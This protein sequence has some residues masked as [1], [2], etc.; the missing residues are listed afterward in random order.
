M[1]NYIANLYYTLLKY[2]RITILFFLIL[3]ST[4]AFFAKDLQKNIVIKD[5]I[6]RD[7]L[8]YKRLS[9]LEEKFEKHYRVPILI[10]GDIGNNLK[11]CKIVIWLENRVIND[12][13]LIT[14]NSPFHLRRAHNSKDK[15]LY[16]TIIPL[17]CHR[18]HRID[19]SIL[20]E[21]IWKDIFTSSKSKNNILFEV[22]L[23]KN[24]VTQDEKKFNSKVISKLENDFKDFLI[25]NNLNYQFHMLSWASNRRYVHEGIMHMSILN[26]LL[27]IIIIFLLRIFFG[28]FRSS[29]LL[30][31]SLI[32]MAIF[33]YGAMAIFNIPIDMLNSGIFLLLS[34]SALQDYIFILSKMYYENKTFQ[35]S[36]RD[37]LIPSFFTSLTTVIGFGS[38]YLSDILI[39]QRFGLCAAFGAIIEW[40]LTFLFLP[41]IVKAIPTFE[42]LINKNKSFFTDQL[43][44]VTTKSIPRILSYFMLIFFIT[45]SYAVIEPN[46]YEEPFGI[47]PEDHVFTKGINKLV[48]SRDWSTS[49]DIIFTNTDQEL[50]KDV[51]TK[52]SKLEGI[53][54]VIGYHDI[55]DFI[56]NTTDPERKELIT[57]ELSQTPILERF[58]NNETLRSIVYLRKNEVSLVANLKKEIAKICQDNKNCYPT[59]NLVAYTEFGERV[60]RALIKSFGT[61]LFLV[62]LI[63]FLLILLNRTGNIFATILSSMWG[64][65]A[66]L[67]LMLILDLP[68]NYI[69]CMFASIIVGLTGDNAIQFIFANQNRNISSGIHKIGGG[70]IIVFILTA[71]C[72]SVF[73]FG[74][75]KFSKDFGIILILGG[76]L[77]LLGDIWILRSLTTRNNKSE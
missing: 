8:D 56:S 11:I 20:D 12:P 74:Y 10:S 69:T 44:S 59:G 26:I 76:F 21:S 45:G 61:S 19:Y 65:F 43:R 49:F 25:Q 51:S 2:H 32:L 68:I 48:Q 6:D 55:I 23:Q 14:I 17:D 70:S 38:L 34:I 41:S 13:N 66:C 30:I 24:D 31:Y 50:I 22:L 75:F 63:I 3:A 27:F 64:P 73:L 71:A 67:T 33:L 47:Y 72:S 15:L 39:L 9:F 42:N 57:R 46:I 77:S 1:F 5:Q 60:P 4:F 40:V 16:P 35:Q 53:T 52:V 54:K 29:T 62:G 36:T 18:H 58:K 28:T 37:L 7:S